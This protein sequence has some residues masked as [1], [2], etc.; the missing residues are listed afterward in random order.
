M[1]S[2]LSARPR[3][4]I[5][6]GAV[7]ALVLAAI[8]ISAPPAHAEVGT[9]TASISGH[10]TLPEGVDPEAA[11]L[12][13][14]AFEASV[15]NASVGGW[16][17][18]EGDFTI[19]YLAAGTY[20]LRFMTWDDDSVLTAWWKDGFDFASAQTVTVADGQELAGVDMTLVRASTISG[21]LTGVPENGAG[22][23]PWR[24]DASGEW[25]REGDYVRI[26]TDGEYLITGLRAGTYTL[27]FNTGT[28]PDQYWKLQREIATATPIE[29]GI[30]Q[31]LTG[32]DAN[33]SAA[34]WMPQL[35]VSGSLQVGSTMQVTATWQ[36]QPDAVT[37]QWFANA[38]AI[39]GA[40]SATYVPTAD[41][42]GKQLS[43]RVDGR[44]AGYVPTWDTAVR[45]TV[46]KGSLTPGVAM[47][48]GTGVVGSTLTASAGGWPSGTQF[49]YQWAYADGNIAGATGKTFT[50][51]TA[52]RGRGIYLKL[53]G[54]LPAYDSRTV[55]AAEHIFVD[56]GTFTAAT[57]T[58]SGTAAVGS[59]LTAKTGTWTTNAT[60]PTK[61]SYKWFASGVAISGATASTYKLTS[62][63]AGKTISV[64]VTGTVGGNIRAIKQ[65]AATAKV[66]TVATP[67]IS[68]TAAV[69][70]TLTAK[71]GT[72]TSGTVFSY[73]WYA[74]GTAITGATASTFKLTSA[75]AGKTVTVTV[76]G[77]LSGYTTVSKSSA[78]TAKVATVATPTISGTAA[79]GSTLTAKPGTWTT[80]TTFSYQWYASGTAISGATSSTFKLT[81][82]QKGKTITVKVTGSLS[83]YP[84]IAKTSAA[85]AAVS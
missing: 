77:A 75:Q 43:V 2:L 11:G 78:A 79:V 16:I 34:L 25:V 59:T 85:T 58:I 3:A 42:V 46:V 60:F 21:K 69:G 65:S 68:G 38:V 52:Q 76:K 22:V 71:P 47:F 49:S 10:V 72:W 12:T 61:F 35:N 84:T 37:Y 29:V 24:R 8:G 39:T 17:S 63:Q 23:F 18:P 70:S 82:L 62:A 44:K 36:I 48:T 19:P 54:T 53:T 9:G 80:G 32:F 41:L 55:F 40:T 51:T 56:A 4:W 15:D 27:L 1:S 74:S 66:A 73:Q 64:V 20:K 13:V 6:V 28:Y 57:P 83:G 33:V 50:I 7:V 31:A 5:V 45:G 81:S 67:T 14:S 26:G 30:G